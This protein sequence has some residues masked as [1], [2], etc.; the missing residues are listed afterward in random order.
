M[1][2]LQ[3]CLKIDR[4]IKRDDYSF[5]D[6]LERR[7]RKMEYWGFNSRLAYHDFVFYVLRYCG[8]R[9]LAKDK[10]LVNDISSKLLESKS[11]CDFLEGLMLESN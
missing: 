1:Q 2:I 9:E 3:F 4:N 6:E 10:I 8:K 7:T 5:A 11:M